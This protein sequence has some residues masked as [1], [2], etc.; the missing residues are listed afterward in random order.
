MFRKHRDTILYAALSALI[1]LAA[2]GVW[3]AATG[4][5]HLPAGVI[6]V[7][8][9]GA[10][11][12]ATGVERTAVYLRGRRTPSRR[13]HARPTARKDTNPA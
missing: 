7:F 12:V 13:A 5:L 8:S 6:P 11:L 4:R 1:A 10:A 3:I 2:V 9:I